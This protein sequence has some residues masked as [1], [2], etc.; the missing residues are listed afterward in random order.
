MANSYSLGGQLLNAVTVIGEKIGS[1]FITAHKIHNGALNIDGGPINAAN[2]FAVQH[3]IDAPV[4]G[5]A[6]AGATSNVATLTS[7][8]GVRTMIRGFVV[9]GLGAT[10]AS[11]V[12]VAVTDGTW[13][14]TFVVNVP[15]GATTII[16]PLNVAFGGDGLP[17]TA[18]NTNITVTAASFGAGNTSATVQAWGVN[19]TPAS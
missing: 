13:T 9:S 18:V 8:A 3:P 6:S 14:L 1:Y 15:A 12:N 17:A 4:V 10:A 16:T 5:G 2:P 7:A 11:A 19:R